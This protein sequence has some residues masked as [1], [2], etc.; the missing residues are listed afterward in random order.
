MTMAFS[1]DK[2]MLDKLNVGDKVRFN[3]EMV[4]GKATVTQ[5]ET[6]R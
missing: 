4:K 6:A 1:A 5:M 2:A 3:A